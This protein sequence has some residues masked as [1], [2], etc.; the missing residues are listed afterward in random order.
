MLSF[1]RPGHTVHGLEH[2]KLDGRFR[3]LTSAFTLLKGVQQR[4]T[5]AILL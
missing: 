4:L 1:L 3:S 5:R 2:G